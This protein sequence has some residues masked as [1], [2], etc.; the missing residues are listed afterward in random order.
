MSTKKLIKKYLAEVPKG[1]ERKL[2]IDIE[3]APCILAGFHIGKTVLT[4]S[5][6]IEDSSIFMVQWSWFGS[7]K[8]H[9]LDITD[10]KGY[11]KNWRD[12][13][14]LVEVIGALM[15]HADVVVGQNSKRFDEKWLK[16]RALKYGLDPIEGYISH[17]T[18]ISSRRHF[19]LLSHKLDYI[20]KYLGMGAK[21]HTDWSWWLDLI[22]SSRQG[23]WKKFELRMKKFRKYGAM[24][25]KL[26]KDVYMKMLPHCP[27]FTPVPQIDDVPHK[28]NCGGTFFKNGT[29]RTQS[30]IYQ[31][32]LCNGCGATKKGVKGL[33]SN[34]N[35]LQ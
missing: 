1:K 35:K 3:T 31:R 11:E 21:V 10:F 23:D 13:S 19:K 7:K 18:L 9:T 25:V 14:K 15:N 33:V 20:A 2:A 30:N 32:Y 28:C 6:I 16:G 5:S 26:L 27:E 34:K 29:R 8:I 22:L 17:D 24:D 4:H 12:D